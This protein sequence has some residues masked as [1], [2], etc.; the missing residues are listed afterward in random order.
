MSETLI[1][2]ELPRI[3]INTMRGHINIELFEDDA[4]NT[5]GNM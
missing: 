4:P 3:Q 1:S 5:V 2:K